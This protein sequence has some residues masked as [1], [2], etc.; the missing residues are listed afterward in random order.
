MTLAYNRKDTH[1]Q[2]QKQFR[3]VVVTSIGDCEHRDLTT[4]Q[5]PAVLGRWAWHWYQEKNGIALQVVSVYRPNGPDKGG[6]YT[7]YARHLRHLLSVDKDNLRDPWLVFL[8]DL[9]KK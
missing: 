3:G 5:D 4:G 6:F 1:I 9:K 2:G 7:V 8:L